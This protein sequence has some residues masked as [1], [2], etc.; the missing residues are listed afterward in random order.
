M[1]AFRGVRDEA[2]RGSRG[3]SHCETG[4]FLCQHRLF[5]AISNVC[6]A[7]SVLGEGFAKSKVAAENPSRGEG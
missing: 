2:R 3:C 4:I 5:V 6:D 1:G 7:R